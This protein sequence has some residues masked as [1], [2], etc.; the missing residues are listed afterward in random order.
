[1][2][3][4]V[5]VPFESLHSTSII[6]IPTT[7]HQAQ[8]NIKSSSCQL[9]QLNTTELPT[10]SRL[11]PTVATSM[12][13]TNMVEGVQSTDISHLVAT[14]QIALSPP[15]RFTTGSLPTRHLLDFLGECQAPRRPCLQRAEGLIS[16]IDR[17]PPLSSPSL[18]P[19][20]TAPSSAFFLAVRR[21]L[22]T[23]LTRGEG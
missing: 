4:R 20:D 21:Y 2:N 8:Q 17:L 12:A 15:S 10:P 7:D 23:Y 6:Y 1:M 11:V 22:M 9:W 16:C 5:P 19:L 14:Q 3:R 18:A 13:I